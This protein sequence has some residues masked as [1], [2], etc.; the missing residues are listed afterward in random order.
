[1]SLR[2]LG[3]IAAG[4]RVLIVGAAGGVGHFAVQIA[5]TY[6][7]HV[8][9]VCSGA[10]ADLVRGL[11]ADA[12]IDYTRRTALAG[13]RPYDLVFDTI[14]RAPLRAFFEVMAPA[15][16]LVSTLPSFGRVGTAL[17]LPLVS[18][19]RIRFSMVKSRAADLD[20]LC[21]LCEAGQLRPVLDKSFALADLAAAHAYSQEGHAAGKILIQ[22]APPA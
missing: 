6:G 21:A 19:R 22:V 5:K 2:D 12:V 11:G 4:H 1:Q 18:R 8:T 14:V 20:Q 7:A 9:A 15:G 17:L 16:V 13:E 3:R 10:R